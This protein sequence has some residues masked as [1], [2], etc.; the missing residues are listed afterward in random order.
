MQSLS[1]FN[2]IKTRFYD[3]GSNNEEEE[4]ISKYFIVVS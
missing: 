3:Y 2:Q 1:N 4:V